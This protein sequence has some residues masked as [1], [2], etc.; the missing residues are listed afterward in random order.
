MEMVFSTFMFSNLLSL[1]FIYL[2]DF[3]H[4]SDIFLY[5]IDGCRAAPRSLGGAVHLFS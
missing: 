3:F 5:L 4:H 2:Q 1:V